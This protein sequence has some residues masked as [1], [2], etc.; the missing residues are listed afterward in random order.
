MAK[1]AELQLAEAIEEL[2]RGLT[3]TSIPADQVPIIVGAAAG[4]MMALIPKG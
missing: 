2:H 1:T 3:G 4:V